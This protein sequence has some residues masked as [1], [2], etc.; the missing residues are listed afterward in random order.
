[1]DIFFKILTGLLLS[2]GFLNLAGCGTINALTTYEFDEY[3]KPN[4]VMAGIRTD[5]ELS[6][7][8]KAEVGRTHLFIVPLLDLPLSLIADII[9]LPYTIPVTIKNELHD[10]D[11]DIDEIYV[12]KTPEGKKVK[13][14][15]KNLKTYAEEQNKN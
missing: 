10:Y 12:I 15:R 9:L 6:K 14:K 3:Y 5:I 4:Q 7:E 2:A 8:L 1:M 11:E 13:V